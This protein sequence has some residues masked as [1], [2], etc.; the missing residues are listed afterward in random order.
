MGKYSKIKTLIEK[1]HFELDDILNMKHDVFN[2][3]ILV[4][5]V[6]KKIE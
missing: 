5:I 2:Q 6:A 3:E 4:N 1:F